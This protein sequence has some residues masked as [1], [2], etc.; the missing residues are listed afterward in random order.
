M[1]VGKWVVECG[2]CSKCSCHAYIGIYMFFLLLIFFDFYFLRSTNAKAKKM[3][4]R[5]TALGV[6]RLLGA[7]LGTPKLRPFS[8][9]VSSE[10][11]TGD[12]LSRCELEIPIR[13]RFDQINCRVMGQANSL[14][15]GWDYSKRSRR[16]LLVASLDC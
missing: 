14:S 10:S 7:S 16:Y 3:L 4:K 1:W 2:M 9:G 11:A 15:R 5:T 8:R 6:S 13:S 12:Y